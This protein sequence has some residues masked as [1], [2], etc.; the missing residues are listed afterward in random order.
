MNATTSA[1]LMENEHVKELLGVM[2]SNRM[3]AGELLAILRYV[4]M[5]EGQLDRAVGEL[6]AMRR[7]LND[8]REV[9]NHPVKTALQN[10]I[11]TLEDKIAVMREHLDALKADIIEGAKKAV[12]AFKEQG[13][14]ALNG[15]A[16][17]LHIKGGLNALRDS[18][19]DGIKADNRAIASIEAASAKY[20]EAGRRVK[21]MGRALT[22][23]EAVQEAKSSGKVARVLEAPFRREKASLERAVRDVDAAVHALE[24]LEA[25]AVRIRDARIA[26][27]GEKK[28][29][30]LKNLDEL[31]GQI[32]QAKQD[33]PV[34]ER[35][36]RQEASL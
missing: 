35:P 30:I 16:S 24:R 15:L 23:K 5:V 11:H 22:D 1:P 32:A 31:K 12:A 34:T 19:N 14:S 26:V 33:A 18:L 21:N 8:M 28:P 29:S 10:A 7:E 9:Q 20:H 36:K 17:F 3:D 13:I 6:S 27:K 25:S 4:G 2:K